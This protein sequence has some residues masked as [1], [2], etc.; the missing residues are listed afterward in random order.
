M[1]AAALLAGN[2]TIPDPSLFEVE[3]V[4]ARAQPPEGKKAGAGITSLD[5]ASILKAA[6]AWVVFQA[7]H[8]TVVRDVR[9]PQSWSSR[10]RL[11]ERLSA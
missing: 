2:A 7:M 4:A 11:Q 3:E 5:V 8:S 9:A 1:V 10:R 6:L